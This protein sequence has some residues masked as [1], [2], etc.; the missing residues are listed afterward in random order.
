MENIFRK[1]AELYKVPYG[2]QKVFSLE[3]ELLSADSKAAWE[4][5]AA[6]DGLVVGGDIVKW[7]GN[8]PQLVDRH[9]EAQPMAK[10]TL[11][12][13]HLSS[14]VKLRMAGFADCIDTE[15]MFVE[16]IEEMQRTKVLPPVRAQVAAAAGSGS[17]KL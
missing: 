5:A 10:N 14:D 8:S 7:L 12:G 2:G 9:R 6:R 1:L 17:S 3:E 11:G 4:K 16:W 15:D 13:S